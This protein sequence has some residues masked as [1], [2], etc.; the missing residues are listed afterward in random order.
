MAE[1]A[2]TGTFEQWITNRIDFETHHPA[3]G[4]DGDFEQWITDRIDFAE[5]VEQEEVARIPRH[6]AY[7]YQ[8]PAIV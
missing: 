7:F 6:P 5:Y 8:I 2:D 3:T 1:P 4:G